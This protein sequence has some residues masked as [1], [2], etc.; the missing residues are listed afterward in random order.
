MPNS[1]W[2]VPTRRH[3]PIILIR[4]FGGLDV[5]DEKALAYQGFND[6]SV[7]PHKRG[8]NYIYEGLILRLLKHRR[9]Y[10]DAT[11]VV[12]YFANAVTDAQ[13]RARAVHYATVGIRRRRGIS[14]P[15]VLIL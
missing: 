3:L 11:N 7:Y 12:G 13:A 2:S 14:M 6:G 4:G 8:E 1:T 15:S 10:H 9:R 5:E